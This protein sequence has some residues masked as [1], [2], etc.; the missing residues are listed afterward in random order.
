MESLRSADRT[1][2]VLFYPP[3]LIISIKF[4]KRYR[5]GLRIVGRE[6]DLSLRHPPANTTRVTMVYI[7]FLFFLLHIFDNFSSR[8]NYQMYCTLKAPAIALKALVW[9]GGRDVSAV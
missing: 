6:I 5:A 4:G 3:Y 2:K 8:V 9:W 1:G 7:F